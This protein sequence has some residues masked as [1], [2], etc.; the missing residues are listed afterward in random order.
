M[1]STKQ[2]EVSI[3]ERRNLILFLAINSV[4]AVAGMVYLFAAEQIPK[5]L[6]HVLPFYFLGVVVGFF[7][8]FWLAPKMKG[9]KVKLKYLNIIGI[10]KTLLFILDNVILR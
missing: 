10:I 7:I 6:R 4:L 2:N 3:K 5:I 9:G 1:Q 8:A